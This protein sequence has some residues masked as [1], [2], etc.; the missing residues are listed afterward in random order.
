MILLLVCDT[1]TILLRLLTAM[2]SHGFEISYENALLLLYYDY[3]QIIY[4]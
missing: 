3:L 1:S 4:L 2:P